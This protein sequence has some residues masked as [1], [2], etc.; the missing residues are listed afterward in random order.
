MKKSDPNHLYLGC[1]FAGFT[2]ESVAAAAEYNDVMSFN[3]YRVTLVPSEWKVLDGIDRPTLV[4]EFHFGATD[5]GL[6]DPG[7]IAV[8][9]QVARGEAYQAYVRSVLDHPLFV[10]C[11]WFQYVDQPLLGR[12]MDGENANVGFVDVTDTPYPEMIDAAR[13]VHGEMYTRR[14]GSAKP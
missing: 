3:V 9:N 13:K 1:R 11:H 5:R 12:A 4:G 8:A 10:G 7:L 2:P 14:F 6:F